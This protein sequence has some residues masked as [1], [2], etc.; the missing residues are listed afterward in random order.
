[1]RVKKILLIVLGCV[2]LG[3]GTLGV[4]LPV[5]PTTPFYLVTVWCFARS[6]EKLNRW[7]R[8][9]KLYKKNLE[10]FVKKEGMLRSTKAGIMGS[11]TLLMSFG[12]F[13]MARKGLWVPCGILAAVW[14][15][16]ILYFCLGVKTIRKET[17][18]REDAA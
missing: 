16:H 9:T 1:M 8:S 15:A 11:V 18:A 6:S 17:T 7:F 14:L 4:A 12:F 5:L 3:L 2:C 13:M 10:S